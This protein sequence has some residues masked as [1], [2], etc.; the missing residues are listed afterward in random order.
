MSCNIPAKDK[1]KSMMLRIGGG[2]TLGIRKRTSKMAKKAKEG[3]IRGNLVCK[4]SMV[5]MALSPIKGEKQGKKNK[6]ES[7]PRLKPFRIQPTMSSMSQDDAKPQLDQTQADGPSQPPPP[8]AQQPTPPAA[9]NNNGTGNNNATAS[10]ELQCQWLDCSERCPTAEKLYDHVCERHVGRKSTNNLNLTCHWGTCR[11]STVK[12]DHITSHIRVHVP[13]KPHHCDFCGKAFKRPQDLKKHVKTHADDSVLLKSPE[14]NGGASRPP[15]MYNMTGRPLPGYYDASLQNQAPQ[16]Y[17]HPNQ[18]YFPMAPQPPQQYTTPVYYTPPANNPNNLAAYETQKRGLEALDQLLG[19]AKR[20]QFDPTSYN[21]MSQRLVALHGLPLPIAHA[22]VGGY[23]PQPAAMVAVDGNPTYQHY[24]LPPMSNIRT[25]SDLVEIGNVLEQMQQAAYENPAQSAAAGT[26]LPGAHYIS[27]ATTYRTSYSPPMNP[28]TTHAADH[29]ATTACASDSAS[30][31]GVSPP[32]SAHSHTSGHSPLSVASGSHSAVSPLPPSGSTLY[33]TLPATTAHDG[34]STSNTAPAS[35]LGTSFSN[36]HARRYSGGM[37]QRAQPMHEDRM[38]TDDASVAAKSSASTTPT[39]HSPMISVQSSPPVAKKEISASVIDPALVD[40][41]L[42]SPSS[43]G[44]EEQ[45]WVKN[46]RILEYLRF[47]VDQEL[48]SPEFKKNEKENQDHE[49]TDAHDHEGHD[50][51]PSP[52][53]EDHS[54]DS[55]SLYPRL[56]EALAQS[57]AS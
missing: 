46:I 55:D 53:K 8:Q 9:P 39:M 15:M 36:D 27:G 32:S 51:H 48:E 37:L 11:V 43:E 17:G 24:A 31:P 20:R 10:T 1:M 57:N 21:S 2:A 6:N 47:L 49:M 4:P 23:E 25:K 34:Y 5:P 44:N 12:R 42:S 13:L 18:N 14:P 41:D 54:F 33:P 56:Q 52:M 26:A 35:A 40:D 22:S 30:T 45:S 29:S 19:D 3:G 38:D 28:T 50:D 7:D 16:G